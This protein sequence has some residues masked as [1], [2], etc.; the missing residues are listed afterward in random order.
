MKFIFF[1]INYYFMTK[2]P[3]NTASFMRELSAQTKTARHEIKGL[4]IDV[5]PGV[6]PPASP[7]SSSAR[8]LYDILVD[9]EGKTVLDVGTGSGVQALIAAKQGAALVHATDIYYPA[10]LCAMANVQQNK[11]DHIVRVHQGHLFEPLLKQTYDVI[12]ANLPILEGDFKDLRWH[13]LF[14]PEFAYHREFLAQAHHYLADGGKVLFTHANLAG[15]RA[16]GELE[17]MIGGFDWN[18]RVI[19]EVEENNITW[20]TYE[21]RK[22]Q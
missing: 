17:D 11:L 20:R 3:E 7:F 14:D 19:C 1:R 13:A 15:L 12:I 5:H 21:L 4:I 2:I 22:T 6:F 8:V 16:F 9:L 18:Y 10:V